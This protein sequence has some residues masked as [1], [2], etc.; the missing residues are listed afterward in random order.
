MDIS[1]VPLSPDVND[2]LGLVDLNPEP[3][4]MAN[5]LSYAD[6]FGVAK[7]VISFNHGRIELDPS[8]PMSNFGGDGAY[9]GGTRPG[10][11]GVMRYAQTHGAQLPN[12]FAFA[13]DAQGKPVAT[14]DYI[15]FADDLIP[16]TGPAI[17]RGWTLLPDRDAAAM[18]SA[19]D[20]L[21]SLVAS[22]VHG[23]PLNGL[24]FGSPKRFLTDLVSMLRLRAAGEE[25][26]DDSEKCFA[27]KEPFRR[28][29]EAF[30]SWQRTHGFEGAMDIGQ[31]A[32]ALR[33][34]NHP[35]IEDVFRN[36]LYDLDPLLGRPDTNFEKI[37]AGFRHME[38]FSARYARAIRRALDEV[39]RPQ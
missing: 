3:W 24:L 33:K 35:A 38:T 37:R 18:M 20:K 27:V 39:Q 5:G 29:V 31:P 12:T 22:R 21:E 2:R 26:A 6:K 10:P 36:A 8:F 1:T 15:A 16:G 30:E 25:F 13:R 23:G 34:L 28:Y 14:A 4:G 7:R 9:E 17:V 11:R 19:A 32:G